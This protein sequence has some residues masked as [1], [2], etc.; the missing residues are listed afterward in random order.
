[1]AAV[2]RATDIHLQREVAIKIFQP[3][4]DESATRAF[5]RRFLR[6]A[7]VVAHLDH[8]NILLVHDYGEQDG[9]AYL[10]MPYLPMGSLKHLLQR[11]RVLPVGE[12]LDLIV[13]ILDALQYAHDRGLIHRDIKPG[14]IL[15]KSERTPMLAD[16]GLVKE[17]VAHD[18]TG[19]GSTSI[20]HQHS[21]SNGPIMG[22][23]DYMAPEQ[24]RG[25][26]VPMSDIYSISI[27]LYEMLTGLHPFRL[28]GETGLLNILMKQ[29]Y[30][31]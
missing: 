11:R 25:N 24:I 8:P 1:M 15:F 27:M 5:F 19:P 3:E 21:L 9:L 14:N 2:F 31:Q 16:F 13:Q 28:N 17:T 22:T 29:L 26:V 12:A 23:P 6:E 7:Q 20:H 18:E 30:E 4:N 10:V